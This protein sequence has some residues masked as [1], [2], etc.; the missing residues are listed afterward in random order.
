MP[1]MGR[2]ERIYDL[3][4]L[5]NF[6]RSSKQLKNIEIYHPTYYSYL[7]PGFT[8]K[9]VVT[10][11]DLIHEIFSE[12]YSVKDKT[13]RKKNYLV[14]NCDGII[15]VSNS[16]KNDLM[17]IYNIP[18]E[19]IKVIYLANSLKI[20]LNISKIVS[21]PYVLYVGNRGGYKNFCLLLKVY[22]KSK[23][24]HEN[25][26]LVCFGGG[27]ASTL[28][29]EIINKHRLENKIIFCNGSDDVLSNL[30]KH[31]SVF[32]F[33]SLHE[34]FGIPPLEAM[35]HGCPVLASDSSSIP[36]VV[37]KA[38]IYFEPTNEDDLSAKLYYILSNDIHRNELIELGYQQIAKFSW[39]VCAEETQDYYKSLL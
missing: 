32:V 26:K 16:T 18:E 23:L 36:E 5:Y 37:G 24:I 17:S 28:E 38:G 3:Y 35:Y 6:N 21:D 30:Y 9:R 10:V 34:G 22:T 8:G 20:S 15:C 33:P 19:K 2:L 14:N 31:A 25:Y 1:K 29:S 4:N 11:H 39:D 13:A 12:Y 7:F 27:S